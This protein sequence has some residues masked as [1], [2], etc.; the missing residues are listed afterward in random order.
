M[1]SLT[2]YYLRDDLLLFWGGHE[3]KLVRHPY[4]VS[5]LISNNKSNI[6][7][8]QDSNVAKGAIAACKVSCTDIFKKYDLENYKINKY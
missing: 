1:K 5:C 6:F 2:Q 7:D 8:D 3:K 4:L